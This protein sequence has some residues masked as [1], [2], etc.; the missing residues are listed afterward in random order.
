M[1]VGKN[2]QGNSSKR[3]Q[4]A[5]KTRRSIFGLILALLIIGGLAF[6]VAVAKCI[7]DLPPF[8]PEQLQFIEASFVYDNQ[9]REI[10][11]LH[12]EQNRVIVS[13]DDIPEHVQRAFIAIEDERFETH[14]GVDIIGFFRALLTNIRHRSIQQG[15]STITQQLARNT[16]LTF[17][18]TYERKI[19][20]VWLALLIEKHFT[21]PEI[22]EMYLNRIYFGHHA[23]GVETAAQT[24]FGKSVSELSLAEGALLAG[25]ISSPNINNPFNSEEIATA[26]QALVLG[27]MLRLKYID[28]KQYE[29][30]L[31]Q[32]LDY[33]EP[34]SVEYPH[35]YFIDYVVHQ[36]LVDI[37]TAIPRFGTEEEAYHAIY[38]EGLRIYTT[39]D[40]TYQTQVENVLNRSELYPRTVY[41]DMNKLREATQELPSNPEVSLSANRLAE[42]IDEEN[43]VPQPQAAVVLANPKTGEITA[44]GGGR[45][46]SRKNNQLLRFTSLRQPGSAIKPIVTY[47]PAFE[48]AILA[49]AG[50]VLDDSPYISGSWAPENF[51]YRFRGLI[52]VRE[53]LL[54]SFNVPAVRAF[55]MLT[56]QVGTR[57]AK[58][59]GISTF[60]PGDEE[61][62][63]T[64]LGGITHGVTALDMTQ[65][66]SVLANEGL[67][68]DLYTIRRI[69]N[70]RGEI[71]YEYSPQPRQILSPQ[72]T[73]IV[74][75]ILQDQ[76]RY[77]TGSKLNIDR[78]VACKTGTTN[79]W[80]DVY[81][82]AYTPNLVA[83]FWMGYD[84]PRVGSIEQGW[85]YSTTFLR[86]I[87]KEVF[88]TLPIENF[89]RPPGVAQVEVCSKS[90][91]LPTELCRAEG[92]VV[93]DYFLE[94]HVP[95][96][97]CDLH[98]ALDIDSTTGLPAGPFVPPHLVETRIFLKR[99]PY[100]V[101]DSRWHGK[102]GRIPEDAKLMPPNGESNSET[103]DSKRPEAPTGFT[104]TVQ[105]DLV[106]LEWKYPAEHRLESFILFRQKKGE[107][108][109]FVASIHPDFRDYTDIL[110][111]DPGAGYTYILYAADYLDRFS[112]PV[113]VKL[114]ADNG[115]NGNSRPPEP[116]EL[117]YTD[118][119]N[120]IILTW[121]YPRAT[122]EYFILE[123]KK[124]PG[125]FEKIATI[126]GDQFN[127]HD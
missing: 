111:D 56:P 14:F 3:K 27:N 46:Y 125:S 97:P 91:L 53:A 104:A 70:R 105:E 15:F 66:F 12:D 19:K 5:R 64:T 10:T 20:E 113:E 99:P 39:M 4:R 112:V 76:V 85:S 28:Q 101:T 38:N 86:E 17:D 94:N 33:G 23:Y 60:A 108:R 87:F 45:E 88:K 96:L 41:V 98:V 48:E 95:R 102:P 62:L 22:L 9:D 100:L 32:E 74:T 77:Y 37:L 35:P 31:E 109:Q 51:D 117:E 16:Y 121:S 43:G 118:R 63:P 47:G 106:F 2:R 73:F 25:I 18:Q 57:Y 83:T 116:S 24:Y 6:G 69:E 50:S 114:K 122:A 30:A 119:E 55:E 127:Y 103:E 7:K 59:M 110:D 93:T 115:G 120:E 81:L 92:T 67:K 44:L 124:A 107:E 54:Y 13:L 78:P 40:R 21:K 123:R 72:S 80:R 52:T 58:E 84:E 1:S 82:A 65:A 34:P 68:L 79:Y 75:D 61:Y 126:P 49:G 42:C 89:K 11:A 29:Q 26:K 36:E 71:I 8:D 90:G